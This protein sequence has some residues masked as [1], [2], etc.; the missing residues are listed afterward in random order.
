MS[1]CYHTHTTKRGAKQRCISDYDKS[2]Q[3]DPSKSLLDELML[4]SPANLSDDQ[5]AEVSLSE[6]SAAGYSCMVCGC[7]P[8]LGHACCLTY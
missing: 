6:S 7:F 8:D 3:P 1:H 5:L 4:S 2:L